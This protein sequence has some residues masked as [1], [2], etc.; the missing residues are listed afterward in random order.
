MIRFLI[1]R[2]GGGADDAKDI[3][4]DGLAILI[5]MAD[6]PEY[7]L[8]SSV[9]TLLYAVCRNLWQNRLREMRRTVP[10]QNLNQDPAVVKFKQLFDGEL[11][12]RSVRPID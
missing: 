12:E 8:R 7:E 10:L 11:D 5:N 4:Q 3:I 1:Y 6:D 9:K 2:M